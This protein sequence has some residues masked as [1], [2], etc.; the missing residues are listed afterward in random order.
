MR[1]VIQN[2]GA[3]GNEEINPMQAELTVEMTDKLIKA[4]V[5]KCLRGW[6]WWGSLIILLCLFLLYV[7]SQIVSGDTWFV[8]FCTAI[9]L[10]LF[11]YLLYQYYRAA[12]ESI[13]SWA[14]VENRLVLYRVTDEG[15]QIK[16]S[17]TCSDCKWSAF[18]RIWKFHDMW[19]LFHGR[20]VFWV[21]PN[22]VLNEEIGDFIAKKVIENGGRVL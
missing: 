7:Y 2:S 13:S 12:R 18:D 16:N 14:K 15:L 9:G 11:V 19:L 5:R 22:T 6:W 20:T 3:A 4:S 1:A 8:G 10:S 17:L 21:F